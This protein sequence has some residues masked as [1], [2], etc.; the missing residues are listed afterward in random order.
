VQVQVGTFPA[1]PDRDSAYEGAVSDG[2]RFE[3]LLVLITK[4]RVELNNKLAYGCQLGGGLEQIWI[5]SIK[6]W[7]EP[8]VQ[9]LFPY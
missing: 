3:D 2:A 7:C 5:I 4:Y 9:V 6:K 8:N 1:L